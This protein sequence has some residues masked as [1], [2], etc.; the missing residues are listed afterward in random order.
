MAWKLAQDV[1]HEL[2]EDAGS[3]GLDTWY[4]LSYGGAEV[5][6]GC[7]SDGTGEDGGG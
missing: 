2:W 4:F 3:R 6:A 1:C 5:D 7:G